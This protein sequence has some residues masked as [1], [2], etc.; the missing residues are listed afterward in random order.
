MP[1]NFVITFG[2]SYSP[3]ALKTYRLRKTKE[4]AFVN[5]DIAD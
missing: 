3:T 2:F 5:G 1:A 4:S